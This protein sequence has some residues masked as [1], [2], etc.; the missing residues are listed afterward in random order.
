MSLN[1]VWAPNDDSVFAAGGTTF[2]KWDGNSWQ[3]TPNGRLVNAKA[4]WG[5]ASDDLWLVNASGVDAVMHWDGHVLTAAQGLPSD[6]YQAIW[7]TDAR[8]VWVSNASGVVHWDGQS[9]QTLPRG[10][11]DDSNRL[12][13]F[14]IYDIWATP[15]SNRP[16]ASGSSETMERFGIG[17]VFAGRTR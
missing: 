14:F 7:G 9:W 11:V 16:I 1:A 3:M 10:T 4:L 5:T 8:N 12:S 2:L 17:M 15:G 13:D 6:A